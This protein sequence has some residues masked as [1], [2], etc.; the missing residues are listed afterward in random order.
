[1]KHK[2]S[3]D[4]DGLGKA[5]EIIEVELNQYKLDRKDIVKSLLASEEVMHALL[6]HAKQ[7]EYIYLSVRRFLD[8]VSIEIAVQGNE[9]LFEKELSFGAAIDADEIGPDTERAIRAMILKSFVDDL[10]YRCRAGMNTVRISVVRSKRAM[11]YRTLGAMVL[12][13]LLG[14]LVKGLMPENL[15]LPVNDNLLVPIKTMYMNALKMIVA[16]VV[17]FSIVS[18]IGQFSDLSEMGKI[19]GKTIALYGFTTVIAT[20]LGTG[21]FYLFRPGKVGSLAVEAG[22]ASM[23]AQSVDISLKDMI[24]NIVPDN[25]FRPFLEAEMMQLIFLAVL[26][27]IAVGMIGKYSRMLSDLFT[28]CNELFLKITSLII[29][30]MPVAVFCS[31]LSMILKMGTEALISILGILGTFA[32]AIVLMMAVYCLLMFAFTRLNPLQFFKK[33]APTMAQVFSM[34]SSNAALPLNIEACKKL[35]VSQKVYS[36]SLPLGAT[37]NMDGTCIYLSVFAF[38]LA[39]LCGVDIPPAALVSVLIS[40]IVLSVGAPGIPGSGLVCL[41]VLLA[42]LNVP[43]EAVALVMG[44]DSLMGMMRC[45]SNCLGDVAISTIVARQEELLDVDTYKSV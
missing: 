19:G 4:L 14:F 31:F 29:K 16:P 43:I 21:V 22:D 24:V 37:M 11:L 42:Q 18:C 27:G 6:S 17:F 3:P 34:G 33:Y 36:L 15:Y 10:K 13:I 26:C 28:A 2:L 20:L 30:F 8:E 23:Q 12:A 38:A 40:I 44:I 7:A 25:F 32:A 39:R 9:F 5:L 1:M 41:S 45:A 35:G